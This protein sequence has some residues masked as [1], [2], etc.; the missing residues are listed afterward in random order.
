MQ[1]NYSICLFL[2]TEQIYREC[3]C[4]AAGG[5][6]IYHV[7]EGNSIPDWKTFLSINRN[8]QELISFLGEFISKFVNANNPL[9]VEQTLYFHP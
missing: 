9:P 4:Q 5:H 2:D 8:K 6:R 7:N 1:N 3:R